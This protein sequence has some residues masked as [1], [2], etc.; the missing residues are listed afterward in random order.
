MERDHNMI[1]LKKLPIKD[2]T[3]DRRTTNVLE[4]QYIIQP[5]KASHRRPVWRAFRKMCFW[6][7]NQSSSWN[8]IGRLAASWNVF[9]KEQDARHKLEEEFS[10]DS[11]TWQIYTEHLS[12]SSKSLAL[13]ENQ[14]DV[15]QM[16]TLTST[17]EYVWVYIFKNFPFLKSQE[18]LSS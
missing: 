14:Q 13:Y 15:R 4:F 7:E 9:I 10:R 3:K 16:S 1:I 5:T 17:H 11:R 2:F 18:M 8:S 6:H 12:R